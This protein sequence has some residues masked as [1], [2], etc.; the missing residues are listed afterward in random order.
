MKS[1]RN[2]ID[3]SSNSTNRCL[4][5]LKSRVFCSDGPLQDD[6]T[7]AQGF[8]VLLMNRFV[9]SPRIADRQHHQNKAVRSAIAVNQINP[10]RQSMQNTA[11]EP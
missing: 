4:A 11:A 9:A 7:P 10:A 8:T 5:L 6:D 2:P 1:V 3:P